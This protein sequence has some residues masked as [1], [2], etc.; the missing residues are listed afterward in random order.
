MTKQT[1]ELDQVQQR[2]AEIQKRKRG[3]IRWHVSKHTAELA[4]G[5]LE[6]PR[7]SEKSRSGAGKTR[8][9]K[10]SKRLL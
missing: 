5:A 8:R 3:G 6:V 7:P 4:I 9:R 10:R 1:P 2:L